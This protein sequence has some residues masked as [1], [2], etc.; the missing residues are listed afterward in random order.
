MGVFLEVIDEPIGVTFENTMDNVVGML[1]VLSLEF[2]REDERLELL[3]CMEVIGNLV[4][5]GI[6]KDTRGSVEVTL[7]FDKEGCDVVI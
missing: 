7:D 3:M 5:I 2:N 4:V 1:T 6:L